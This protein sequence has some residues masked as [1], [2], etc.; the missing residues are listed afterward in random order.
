[1]SRKYKFRDNEKIYFVTLTVV[2]WIDLF[3][4]KEY[5]DIIYDSLKFCQQNKDLEIYAYCIMT[6]HIH[7]IIGSKGNPMSNILRDFKKHTS[8]LLKH[9]IRENGLESRKEWILRLMRSKG[10]SNSNNDD[11][12]L[13]IQNNHPILLD[14]PE[15][16]D[17]KLEYIHNNPVKAGFIYSPDHWI[18][19]SARYYITRENP[20]IPLIH[21][22]GDEK[23]H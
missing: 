12:Q 19:S 23:E 7:L 10:K 9:Q 20:I 11:F 4:R 6:S 22:D 17:Q 13:W 8:Y 5:K 16:I 3:I 14:T 1:M 18:D 21:I 15:I 2:E